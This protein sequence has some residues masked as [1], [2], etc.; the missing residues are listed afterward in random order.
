MVILNCCYNDVLIV[1]NKVIPVLNSVSQYEGI[2]RSLGIASCTLMEVGGQPHAPTSLCL[3][4][5][6]QV[7]LEGW[8]GSRT[9]QYSWRRETSFP[10]LGI[11]PNFLVIQRIAESLSWLLHCN[12]CAPYVTG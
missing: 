4:K 5:E 6:T 1:S 9:S 10:M 11:E 3:A 8:V 2:W 12:K 7:S